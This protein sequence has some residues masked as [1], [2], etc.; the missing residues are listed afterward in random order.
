MVRLFI[1]PL[2]Q[3]NEVNQLSSAMLIGK[4]DFNLLSL[5]FH[6]VFH[7]FPPY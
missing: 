5:D 3:N 1:F 4:K 7:L 6:Y 2:L